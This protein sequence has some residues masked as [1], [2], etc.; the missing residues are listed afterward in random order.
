MESES[1]KHFYEILDR[2]QETSA[3]GW[4]HLLGEV[5]KKT[6]ETSHSVFLKSPQLSNG[7]VDAEV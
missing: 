4:L 2:V 5:K 7:S 3:W 1:S 6:S